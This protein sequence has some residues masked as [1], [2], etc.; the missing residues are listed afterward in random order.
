MCDITQDPIHVENPPPNPTADPGGRIGHQ[1]G[2]A[3][4]WFPAALRT[5]N[6]LTNATDA[7]NAGC[8]KDNAADTT[9][10]LYTSVALKYTKAP[11]F[12][13]QEM[14]GLWVSN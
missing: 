10:C 2:P 11:V 1:L 7:V 8:L 6:R 3:G 9:R 4:D 14:P 12:I 13:A 5:L